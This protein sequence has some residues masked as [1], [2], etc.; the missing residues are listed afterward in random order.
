MDRELALYC[1]HES[2]V[3]EQVAIAHL[4]VGFLERQPSQIRASEQILL[5]L[6]KVSIWP[7]QLLS[8]LL[9]LQKLARELTKHTLLQ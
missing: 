9:A 1:R 4:L 8:S 2:V 5:H 3:L 6:P 7:T